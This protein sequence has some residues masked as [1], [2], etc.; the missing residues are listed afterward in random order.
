[1]SVRAVLLNAEESPA[2]ATYLALHVQ[3]LQVNSQHN[4]NLLKAVLAE[5]ESTRQQAII[6]VAPL[7][8]PKD[9][10]DD[11]KAI[12]VVDAKDGKKAE[13]L[14]KAL[15]TVARDAKDAIKSGTG[16][17]PSVN[18]INEWA[19]GQSLTVS[20]RTQA[21][22][23]YSRTP[24]SRRACVADGRVEHDLRFCRSQYEYITRLRCGGR[25]CLSCPVGS[26]HAGRHTLLRSSS[27]G[28]S[29]KQRANR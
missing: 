19:C 17:K 5:S 1:M 10:S 12:V 9:D 7:R 20:F 28:T 21:D 29:A 11:S 4:V 23:I 13:G 27:N 25:G 16:G 26:I 6:A 3:C 24:T 22:H 14:K 8:P 18:D 15:T 2:Y